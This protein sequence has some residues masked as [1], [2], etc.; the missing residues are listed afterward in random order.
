[1]H[2]YED[3]AET[4]TQKTFKNKKFTKS[5]MDCTRV[6]FCIAE[7]A[8]SEDWVP[9]QPEDITGFGAWPLYRENNVRYFGYL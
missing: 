2:K 8:P 3:R 6:M 9:A 1:M 4:G 5:N 7:T